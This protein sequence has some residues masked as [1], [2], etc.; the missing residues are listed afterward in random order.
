M[1]TMGGHRV[2]VVTVILSTTLTKE[3]ELKSVWTIRWNTKKCTTCPK[4]EKKG[5]T[6]GKRSRSKT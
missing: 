6:E 3:V 5:E 4:E 2:D 1:G